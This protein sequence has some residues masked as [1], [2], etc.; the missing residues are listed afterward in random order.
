MLL[1]RISLA[2]VL[3]IALG[4]AVASTDR[5]PVFSQSLAQNPE[6]PRGHQR[7]QMRLME[8]LDLTS[9]QQ[10]RLQTIRLQYHNEISQHQQELG[11]ST[12]NLGELMAGT[13]SVDQIRTQHKQVQAISHQ[14]EEL[15]FESLLAMRE[16]LTPEQRQRFATM[17]QQRRG[18]F[19]NP[20]PN[21]RGQEF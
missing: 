13:A 7:G 9:E 10:E 14:L 6:Q 3:M 16:V 15:R 1:H 2:S 19:R 20:T 8:E 11:Q 21:R 12:Q 18:E 5:N 17:M 4:G